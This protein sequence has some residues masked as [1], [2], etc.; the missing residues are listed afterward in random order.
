[1]SFVFTCLFASS[2]EMTYCTFKTFEGNKALVYMRHLSTSE[3]TLR[4]RQH[5]LI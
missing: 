2:L 5:V 3:T 1:M 4:S